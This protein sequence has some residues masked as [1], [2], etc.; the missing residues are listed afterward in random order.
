MPKGISWIE[1][2]ASGT[3]DQDKHGQEVRRR[4]RRNATA[5]AAVGEEENQT[6]NG[7]PM[8]KVCSLC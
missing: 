3:L 6:E 1:Y 4:A 8:T 2:I 7:K 5:A